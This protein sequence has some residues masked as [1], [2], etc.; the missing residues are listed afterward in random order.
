MDYCFCLLKKLSIL[1]QKD[2]KLVEN[3]DFVQHFLYE[4]FF[5]SDVHV[6]VTFND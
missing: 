1:K 3:I 6:H 5:I 4:V 2:V